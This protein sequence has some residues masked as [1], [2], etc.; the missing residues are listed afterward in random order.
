MKL[1]GPGLKVKY[2]GGYGLK[3]S[4]NI[5]LTER[6]QFTD[7]ILDNAISMECDSRTK[8][9]ELIVARFRSRDAA[10]IA[11]LMQDELCIASNF[12]TSIL[13]TE[14]NQKL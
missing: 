9:I 1:S 7:G 14:A 5:E 10:E 4:L 3:R 13:S 11:G 6:E 8:I 12:G 2:R